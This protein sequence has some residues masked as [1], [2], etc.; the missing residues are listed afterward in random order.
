MTNPIIGLLKTLTMFALNKFK[1]DSDIIGKT[2]K[3]E[4]GNSFQIFRRVEV[5][6]CYKKSPEAYFLVRFRPLD[7]TPEE[8]IKFSKKP[9]MIFMGFTGFRSKYWAVNDKTGLCQGLYEWQRAEDAE[10]YSKSIAMR[11]MS[12]RSDPKSIFF[13]IID[14]RKEQLKFEII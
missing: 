5:K 7:M 4:D 12:K 8:N 3:M 14:K 13:K 2:I 9:M 10:K 6:S 11:F 1:F